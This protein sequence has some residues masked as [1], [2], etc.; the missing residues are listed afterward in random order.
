MQ[1]VTIAKTI[2]WDFNGVVVDDVAAHHAGF[3]AVLA[4]FDRA[5]V[6]TIQDIQR[7]TTTPYLAAFNALGISNDTFMARVRETDPLYHTT[8][9]SHPSAHT[10]R[11][12]IKDA[13][14]TVRN[15]G[16]NN[17]ILSNTRRDT[18]DEQL[19]TLGIADQFC[20]VS[21]SD[22]RDKTGQRL[23]KVARLMPYMQQ[24]PNTTCI[25][26]D[27]PEEITVARAL[28]LTGIAVSG[29]WFDD[30]RLH[31]A[32]PDAFLASTSDLP[33]LLKTGPLFT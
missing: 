24:N 13:L 16:G 10:L 6:P 2:V 25:I 15:A 20:W 4:L 14:E 7:L 30:A 19:H 22:D 23:D 18:L 27:S 11:P 9:L 5:P 31:A 26:G 29:G 33:K 17:I 21:T 32:R 1:G 12:G 3:N 8:Y 28:G